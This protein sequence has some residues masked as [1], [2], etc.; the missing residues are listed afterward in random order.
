ML[1][2]APTVS[3]PGGHQDMQPRTR[4]AT[5]ALVGALAVGVPVGPADATPHLGPVPARA[6]PGQGSGDPGT[7]SNP[8]PGPR[9]PADPDP[10]QT[11]ADGRDDATPVDAS[12]PA[13]PV[14]DAKCGQVALTGTL[15]TMIVCGPVTITFNT[16]T[17]TAT[18]TTVAAPITAANG[19]IS[20]STNP[21]TT[22][23]SPVPN[24]TSKLAPSSSTTSQTCS[25]KTA[26]R[27]SKA[28][29]KPS[30]KGKHR[31]RV[32]KRAKGAR[33]VKVRV[34]VTPRAGS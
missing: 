28:K 8:P 25:K 7:V 10:G 31:A 9:Q 16:I 29:K 20:T 4:R 1:A 15:P 17:T 21:V 13:A 14:A 23:T 18:T 3:E 24:T 6:A 32:V 2:A 11:G 26:S 30:A 34:V 12:T 5:A 27:R 22:T 33:T 19:A